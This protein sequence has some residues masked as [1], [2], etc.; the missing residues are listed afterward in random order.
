MNRRKN[1]GASNRSPRTRSILTEGVY[2]NPHFMHAATRLIGNVVRIQTA[3]GKVWEG[4][5]RTFSSQLDIVLEVA[6]CVEN[7]D[8]NNATLVANSLVDKLIFKAGDIISMDAK[9]VDLEFATR[10]TFKTD[11]AISARTNGQHIRSEEKELEPWV[12][13]VGVNGGDTSLELEPGANGWDAVDMFKKNEEIYGVQSTYDNTLTGYTVQ[14]QKSDTPDYREREALAQQLANEIES[15]PAYKQRIEMENGDEE[16]LYAAVHRPNQENNYSKPPSEQQNNSSSG[17][18]VPPAKRKNPTAGK[19][20]RSTPP[21][22]QSGSVQTTPSPKGNP[23]PL[24]Y[25]T[26]HPSPNQPPHPSPN[27]QSQPPPPQQQQQHREPPLLLRDPPPPAMT[28]PHPMHQPPPTPSSQSIPPPVPNHG[29]PHSHTPPHP[30]YGGQMQ[31]RGSGGGGQGQGPPLPLQASNGHKSV[32]GGQQMNGEMK[33]QPP[34]SVSMQQQQAQQ[35]GGLSRPPRNVYSASPNSAPPPMMVAPSMY[36]EVQGGPKPDAMNCVP[37]RHREEVKELHKFSQDFKLAPHMGEQTLAPPNQMGPSEQMGPP[38]PPSIVQ[39]SHPAQQATPPQQQQPPPNIQQ[40]QQP[41]QSVSP[42]QQDAM[43]KV[44]NTLKQSKLNPNAKEFVLNPTAK[45]FTPRSPS[46]PTASRPHTPQTPSNP[47]VPPV[48]SGPQG[49]P[50]MPMMMSMGYMMTSQP[51]YQQQPQNNRFRKPVPVGQIRA[52]M[53]QMQVAAATGQPL[54]A[55]API[56]QFQIY[57]GLNPQTAYQQMH[58]VRMYESP[59]QLQYIPSNPSN[60]PSPAQPPPY[61]P[62]GQGPPPQ[63]QQYPAAPPQGHP[64]FQMMCPIIQTQPAAMMQASMHYLQQPPPGGAPIQ[65]IVPHPQQ[66][67]GPAP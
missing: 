23:P 60:A 10:D 63:P 32:G 1:R 43:D 11:T 33:S 14:L 17:K 4:V 39:K 22:S 24:S 40:Q 46:T 31:T 13:P 42:Q 21:P 67:H 51:Q 57:Q 12:P 7:P 45:P 9:D 28:G 8:S 19:L 15:Q 35:G 30:A 5:F 6:A 25:P 48:L 3:S 44:T 20:M 34:Q 18:Y 49:Q 62:G 37:T 55:P 52:D 58:A 56:P 36:Q 50:Q 66:Q 41:Q 29:R 16:T 59:P 38:Q 64:Q 47:Y 26:Q 27:Q 2:N 53:T 54:L 65:V 61:T